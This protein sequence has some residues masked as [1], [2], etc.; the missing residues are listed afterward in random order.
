M[1]TATEQLNKERARL[2]TTKLRIAGLNNTADLFE[3]LQDE[4][5]R[6]ERLST[7][8]LVATEEELARVIYEAVC[9]S[10]DPGVSAWYS[11]IH[12]SEFLIAAR[13]VLAHLS[14]GKEA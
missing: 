1:T 2:D 4:I 10:T 9:A 5:E 12:R 3:A 6:L 14:K 8:S 7:P 13:A 11:T